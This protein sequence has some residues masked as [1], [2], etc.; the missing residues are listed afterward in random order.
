MVMSK[1][2]SLTKFWFFF[3]ET[4]DGYNFRSIEKLLEQD[5]VTEPVRYEKPDRPVEDDPF[6]I[7]KNN[8]NFSNDIGMNLRM[9][10]YA[11]KTIYVD[12]ANQTKQVI[13]LKLQI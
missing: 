4:L 9:G 13:D 1:V 12:I 7:L 10:M 2:T 3:Y 11:N 8:L 6:R 5:L